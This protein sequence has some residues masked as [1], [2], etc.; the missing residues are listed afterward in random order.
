MATAGPIERMLGSE[1]R[2]AHRTLE[3][4]A[5]QDMGSENL[6]SFIRAVESLATSKNLESLPTVH[7]G[8][9]SI[10]LESFRPLLEMMKKMNLNMSGQGNVSTL[11]PQSSPSFAS[12]LFT[13][14]YQSGAT[15][16]PF[17]SIHAALQS[18]QLP[19]HAKM[20]L[21]RMLNALQNFS[22][23]Q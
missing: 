15:Q 21:G 5:S 16:S 13:P 3:S 14:S 23:T 20:E 17:Q 8:D 4:L 19:S 6:D 22:R 18:S 7:L 11:S 12:S 2:I 10:S 1:P 9:K